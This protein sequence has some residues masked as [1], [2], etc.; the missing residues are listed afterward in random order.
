[1]GPWEKCQK[2]SLSFHFLACP[3]VFAM[4]GCQ[5][6]CGHYFALSGLTDFHHFSQGDALG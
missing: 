2:L 4:T 6:V 3:S 1:M 5:A